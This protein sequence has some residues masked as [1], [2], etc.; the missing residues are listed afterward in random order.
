MKKDELVNAINSICLSDEAKEK[1]I[2]KVK[3]VGNDR[4]GFYM[5]KKKATALL[6]VATLA[7]TGIFA[8]VNA[9]T[10]GELVDKVKKSI[11]MIFTDENGKQEIMEGTTYTNSNNHTI[12]KYQTEWNGAEYTVEIDK[13]TVNDENLIIEGNINEE[14]ANINIKDK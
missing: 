11:Q 5:S 8:T 10:N 12:E 14:G 3:S 2:S 6:I 9:G 7:L 13:N 4:E 1:I